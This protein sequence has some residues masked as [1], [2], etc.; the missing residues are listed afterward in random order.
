MSS[1]PI[2][3]LNVLAKDL[4]NARQI[5][6]ATKGKVYVGVMVK[7]F[8]RI[9]D[10]V[11]RVKKYQDA[12]VPVS[13]GLGGGDPAQWRRVIDVAVKTKPGHVNQIFPAVGYT[14][15]ALES[16]GSSGTLVNALIA[17]T[18]IPGKVSILTG[19]FS[20]D[21]KDMLSCDAAAAFMQEIGV[22]S[23]KF[24]PIEGDK[25]LDELAVM[26]KAAVKHGITIFEPT[27]G[28]D[29]KSV[30]PVVKT[31]LE[32]GAKV[33]IP[34]IYTAFVDKDTGVTNAKDVAALTQALSML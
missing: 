2:I 19:P 34:H 29:V 5:T 22:R 26:V 12:G 23:I 8:A 16:A 25:R 30:Y 6:E 10:A 9:E 4:E 1:S 3:R 33:V 7:T 20:Q 32:N 11:T 28:I 13:V 14:L 21:Y 15:G 17:P 24:Y 31:C 27:G 18:G